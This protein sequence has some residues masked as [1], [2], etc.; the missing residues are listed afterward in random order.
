MA[1]FVPFSGSLM[2]PVKE[3]WTVERAEELL[4]SLTG[5]VSARVVTDSK[6]E[7]E[8]IHVLTTD[9]VGAKQTVRNVESALYAHLDLTVD[10]RRI[11][12]AQTK[13]APRRNGDAAPA[14]GF[15]KEGRILFHRHLAE[16]ERAHRIRYQVEVELQGQ[17]YTGDASGADVPRSRLDTVAHATLRGVEAAVAAGRG[18]EPPAVSLEL[19]GVRLVEAFERTYALVAVHAIGARGIMRLSGAAPVD[20]NPDRAVIM[21]TLQATDRW[22]RGRLRRR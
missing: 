11:S 1:L 5:V 6:G 13:E 17:R 22:V 2:P 15:G 19:D 14:N 7:V 3:G 9:A 20:G 10:H 4:R 18:E 12:V 16:P 21:A 8:E